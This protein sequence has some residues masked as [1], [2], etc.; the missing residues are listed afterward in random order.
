M[1]NTKAER[2]TYIKISKHK[3][4]DEPDPANSQSA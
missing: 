2:V 1:V 3:I 4:L